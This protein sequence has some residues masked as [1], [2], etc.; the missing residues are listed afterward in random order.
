MVL[1]LTDQRFSL[2]DLVLMYPNVRVQRRKDNGV[3]AGKGKFTP[4]HVTGL[5]TRVEEI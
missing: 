5:A 2:H 1:F 4:A 3:L